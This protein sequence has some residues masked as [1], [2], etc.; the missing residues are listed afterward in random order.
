MTKNI[1]IT[2]GTGLVGKAIIELLHSK[3]Y[4]LAVLSR[5]KQN[6][7]LK[8]FL[9]D[10]EK[11]YIDQDAVD[12]ADII[13]HLAGENISSK[14]WTAKQK[15]KIV[16]SRV[17]STEFLYSTISKSNKKPKRFISASAVGFY[18]SESSDKI[19]VESD[20]PTNDFLASTVVQWE[21]AVDL[22]KDLGIEVS[23]LRLGVVMSLEG[24]ALPKMMTS[25]KFGFITPLGNGNQYIP[26]IALED[27]A[28]LFLFV[29]EKEKMQEVYNAVNPSLLTNKELMKELAKKKK[30]I[31][32]PVGIPA[33]LLKLGLGQMSSLLLT[34]NKISADR[35]INE[36]FVFNK[37]EVI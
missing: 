11:K 32:F 23:K 21:N 28:R 3:G 12:F 20:S 2:G 15:K 17:K 33:F 19:F 1:L 26:W 8:T 10:Y 29:L 25:L 6:T 27:L 13:I 31:Y 24:G 30:G 18:G 16:D 36:G 7:E 37:N 14:R 34:G 5:K 9:W 22:F 35:L 4:N